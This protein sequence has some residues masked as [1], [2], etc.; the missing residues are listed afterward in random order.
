MAAQLGVEGGYRLEAGSE[1]PP[2]LLDDEEAVAIAVGLRTAAQGAVA[3]ME[4]ISLR[5][6]AKLEQVLP[7]RLRR[8][9]NALHSYTLPLTAT[10]KETV[11]P[12]ALAIL[13]LACRDQERLRFRYTARDGTTSRRMTEPHR[14][15]STGRRWYLVAWDVDRQDWRTFRVD[16]L[17]QLQQTA[18]R[19]AER[20]L[21]EGDAAAFVAQAIR[22]PFSTHQVA[23]R[24]HAPLEAVADRV[25]PWGGVLEAVD[26][27]SCVL[28]TATDSMEWTAMF[29]GVLGV[30]FEVLEPAELT[31]CMTTIAQRF[32]RAT[33]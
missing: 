26:E 9:V 13:T 1:L 17:D 20:E 24:L 6:L 2:L 8:R 5:A 10:P 25:P 15:V 19:F 16:R 29:I 11:D 28:R 30:D 14:L 12:E 31:D 7:S 4:E 3:G 32:E 33:A 22:A 27:H 18:V 21:P 23:V